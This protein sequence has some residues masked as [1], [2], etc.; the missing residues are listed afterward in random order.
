MTLLGHQQQTARFL[1]AFYAGRLPQ[2]MLLQGP[3]GVGKASFA[4]QA[5]LFLLTHYGQSEAEGDSLFGEALPLVKS[6]T[7]DVDPDTSHARYV[8]QDAHPDCLR[9]VRPIDEKSG[10]RKQDIPADLIRT[11]KDF[12]SKT[13]SQACCKVVIIDSLDETNPTGANALLKNIEE[14]TPHTFFFLVNHTPAKL[15]PTIRSRCYRMGFDAL[16]YDAFTHILER[17][18]ATIEGI[19]MALLHSLTHGAV[20]KALNLVVEEEDAAIVRLFLHQLPH[21]ATLSLADTLGLV[22]KILKHSQAAA[23]S[24]LW[25]EW[26][27]LSIKE[28]ARQGQSPLVMDAALQKIQTVWAAS[29]LNLDMEVVWLDSLTHWQQA[30]TSSP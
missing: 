5:A 10:K 13:P 22:S 8:R 20:G 21:I 16:P 24:S 15:L 19:D 25:L 4:M 30:A 18:G 27:R 23:L 26:L 12:L 17:S 28:R 9:L 14:P 1:D 6:N 7:L 2:A 3:Q 29:R 11:A